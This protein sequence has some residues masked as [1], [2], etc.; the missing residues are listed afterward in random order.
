MLSVIDGTMVPLQYVN[1][2]CAAQ[3]ANEGSG[4]ESKG[5]GSGIRRVKNEG[6]GLDSSGVSPGDKVAKYVN[7]PPS[8]VATMR[9]EIETLKSQL[10]TAESTLTKNEHE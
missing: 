4:P 9:A 8:S 1:D 7:L 6:K 5:S 3:L 2:M 10:A